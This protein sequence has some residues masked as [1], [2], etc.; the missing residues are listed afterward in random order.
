[1]AATV[2]VFDVLVTL[3]LSGYLLYHYGHWLRHRIAVTV[4][5]LI[6]WYFSFLIIFVLPL[7]VS[8]TAYRQCV[9]L[10][11]AETMAA[12][13]TSNDSTTPSS[14]IITEKDIQMSRGVYD[15][16]TPTSLMPEAG[17]RECQPPYSLLEPHVLPGLWQVV[18]WSS[19]L[20]TWLILPLMQSYTLAGEFT[21]AGKLRSALWDNMLY[22]ASLVLI[23]IILFV[24]IALQ[25]G[26][27]LNWQRLKAIAASASNTWGLF[28]LVF[29]LGYGLVEVPRTLWKH[30]QRGYQLN[31][32]YFK[33]AKLMTERTDSEES[34]DDALTSL[35]GVSQ[36]I[37]QADPRRSFVDTITVKVPLE[38]MEKIQ[39]RRVELPFGNDPPTEKTLTKL[40]RQVM[41]SLQNHH[42]TEAQWTDLMHDVFELEDINR[43]MI[44]NEHAYKHTL[45]PAP[46]PIL[47]R[48]IYTPTMEWYW[49]CLLMPLVLRFAA[50]IA[51]IMSAMILWSEVTFFC[52]SPPLSLFAVF[53]NLA[54][55]S[56]DYFAIELICFFTICYLCLCV[57][58]TIFKI[59]VLNYYYLAK[60]HQSDEYT[61]LFSGALLCRLTPPLCLNFLSLIHMDSHVIKSQ[62]METAYT[63]IMGHM[64]V[65]SIV[66]DYFNIYFPIGLLALSV[67]T[68]FSVGARFLS[69]LGFQQFLDQDAEVTLEMVDE[70]K[71][72]VKREKRRIQRL[73]ESASRRRD[74]ASRFGD[75][76]VEQPDARI[77]SGSFGT[78]Y[79]SQDIVKPRGSDMFRQATA[80]PERSLLANQHY[81]SQGSPT[82]SSRQPDLMTSSPMTENIDLNSPAS[83]Y[84]SP[85]IRTDLRSEP[86]RNIFDDM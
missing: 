9:N 27:H 3:V 48:T 31:R 66:S 67:A 2:F 69:A 16:T 6:A 44:S 53:V 17:S 64:D 65:I 4:S 13:A 50:S 1:M 39:R 20:L 56:Y 78:R 77:E 42:R 63:Q 52:S 29:M 79:R 41:F 62:I 46:H 59:R 47:S 71:E 12:E 83:P 24:Y 86:P 43:N 38:M 25:P 85:T 68:Y 26:L 82:L 36:V 35:Y 19:Q 49:K 23:A 7:D 61:L 57:Y 70:G 37:G 28:V 80:S 84:N 73:T 58:Y 8:S 18:Y 11:L 34:L 55:E 5:V 54:K 60:N 81:P 45:S 10:T 51:V 72:H 75:T 32:A 33:V 15:S 21:P 14:T 74:F 76:E 30:T 40:H 22:Y